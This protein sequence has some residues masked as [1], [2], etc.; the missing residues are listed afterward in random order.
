MACIYK[1]TNKINGKIYIGLTIRSFKSRISNHKNNFIKNKYPGIALYKAFKK[2]G[3]E[4]FESSIIVEGDF[5]KKLLVELEKHYIRLH[6]SYAGVGNKGYNL[7]TGG[8]GGENKII[9]IESRVKMSIAQKNKLYRPSRESIEKCKLSR[10]WYKPTEETKRKIGDF[11]RGRERSKEYRNKI[12]KTLQGHSYN[13]G[14]IKSEEH[15][16]K[17]SEATKNLFANGFRQ[18]A[19]KWCYI[20]DI[21]DNLL[22]KYKS[23]SD[24]QRDF[25]ITRSQA[26]KSP[27]YL[28]KKRKL[29]IIIS[30]HEF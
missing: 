5:N 1:I 2:Y 26:I 30:K 4:N 24:L 10:A 20:Y 17:L 28:Y 12:S 21:E 18:G 13:K 15:R 27:K 14:I 9:T 7:T 19:S 29:K 22:G 23:I 6:N 8:E 3:Y 16:K 11:H 25:G